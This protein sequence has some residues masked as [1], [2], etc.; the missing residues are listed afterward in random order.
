MQGAFVRAHIFVA[1]WEGGF[2]NHPNDPGGAT[3]CGVSLRW[4]QGTGMDVNGDGKI[5]VAD[6]RAMT[7]ELAADLFRRYF[8]DYLGLEGFP[9]CLAATVYDCAVNTGCTQAVRFLQRA[10]DRYAGQWLAIDGRLGPVTRARVSELCVKVGE[11]A[12]CK[13]VIDTRIE[14]YH[15]LVA[16]PPEGKDYR[17]F[18]SGWLNRA[19]ALWRF[20]SDWASEPV[21]FSRKKR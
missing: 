19:N 16:N 11:A 6:I 8:W 12:L 4:L 17:P 2:I 14:F 3:N 10:C 20:V 5:D 9:P 21:A 1:R 18:L 7:P 13:A 15:R